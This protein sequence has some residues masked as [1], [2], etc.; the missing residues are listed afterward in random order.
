MSMNQGVQA[1][2][3][4]AF[5]EMLQHATSSDS[6]KPKCSERVDIR[7]LDYVDDYN[8]NLMCPICHGP[9]VDPCKIPCDHAFC[10]ECLYEA[11][12]SQTQKQKTCPSC[13]RNIGYQDAV[14]L[15]RFVIHML[16]DLMVKCQNVTSGCEEEMRRGDAQNHVE[17]YCSYANL[18]CPFT[19]CRV[20]VRRKDYSNGCP[21]EVVSCKFCKEKMMKLELKVLG[22]YI[23]WS[24]VSD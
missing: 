10:Q 19:E 14:P 22:I 9:F 12:H 20:E 18:A 17:S 4:S 24:S 3:R 16:D 11:I 21:H 13:R 6:P 23:R 5:E 15:P 2:P 1:Q 7:L 8:R